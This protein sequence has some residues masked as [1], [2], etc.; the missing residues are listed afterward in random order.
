M[1]FSIFRNFGAITGFPAQWIIFKRKTY[2]EDKKSQGRYVKGGA[3][4]VSNHF[5][6]LDYLLNAFL[7]YPRKLN[8]V[9]AE[10]AFRKPIMRFFMKFI[11]GIEANRIT[12][13]PRFVLESIKV[14]KK[15]QLVQ[16]FPEGHNTD[17]GTI[18]AFY[19]SCIVIALKAKVPIVPIVSDG[20][21][22][23]FK[24]THV[25]IGKQIDLY[26]YLETEKYTRNDIDR[27]NDIVRNKVLA[28]R[29]ELDARIKAEKQKGQC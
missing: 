15:G 14:L 6:A 25:I 12:K 5:N 17:D 21:Y 13:S 3:L 19:P 9:A 23:L 22:G 8:A 11:G 20:N 24:R 29:E 28:L 7:L 16:I 2:Y 10:F 26:D 18:K 1:F 4:I 27:L